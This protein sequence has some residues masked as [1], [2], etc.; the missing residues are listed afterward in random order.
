MNSWLLVH[1]AI[2]L[3]LAQIALHTQTKQNNDSIHLW[4]SSC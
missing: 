3:I 1:V 4:S 2:Q